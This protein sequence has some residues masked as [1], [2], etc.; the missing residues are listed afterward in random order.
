[1]TTGPDN[2]ET[3]NGAAATARA[4]A[5]SINQRIFETTLDLILVVD[6]QGNFIRVSPSSQS[7]LGYRPE[8]L[9]GRNAIDFLYPPDLD[10]TREEM[11]AARRGRLMRNFECR[12]VR[13]DGQIVP[14]TWT[15]VWSEPDQQH[16]FIGRDMTERNAQEER[17]R[18]SQRLEA[19]GQ[20]TGGI[21]HDF[22]NILGIIIGNLDQQLD[23]LRRLAKQATPHPETE[24]I[25]EQSN[26][27]MD[28]AL[29]GAE[30]VRQLLAFSRNQPLR[31]Q[32]VDLRKVQQG[33]EPLLH[34]TLGE[35]IVIETRVADGLW[36]VMADPTQFENAVL[37]LAINA[38]DA[39]PKG[40]RL[41]IACANAH[42]D[43]PAA[44]AGELPV[45]DFVTVA[46]SDTGTGIA[47]DVLPLVF[48]PFFTTKEVGKGT[49]LGLSMVYGYARQSGGTVKVYS[50][51]GH[52]TEIRLYLPR[53]RTPTDRDAAAEAT[54]AAPRGQERILVV[55][56]KPEVRAVAVRLLQSLGYQ[57]MEAENAAAALA[58]LD[59]GERFDLLFTDFIMPGKMN[60][61]D[62]AREVR[63]RFPA[64]AVVFTSGFSDPNTI[65]SEANALGATIISKPY[66][67]ADL[68]KHIRAALDKSSQS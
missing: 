32:V 62:L 33:F 2:A 65:L 4:A 59:R 37:N 39:M 48:E 42:V 20:L 18:R 24:Q 13:R 27:A 1:M 55:E 23:D 31:P 7:I 10:S 50:E 34:S 66:R 28:A 63:Q 57:S 47:P 36:S 46:V 45:G 29:R 53:A 3:G 9:V 35:A 14:L 38:R 6:S 41:T 16:F 17:L 61:A 5:H 68:A 54:T 12:Y 51:L 40:G 30:L 8:E 44:T 26:A 67:K 15:G 19:V 64:L 21:A 52:G 11:R 25:A 49:G 22:N 60:G 43:E 56:D 58:I